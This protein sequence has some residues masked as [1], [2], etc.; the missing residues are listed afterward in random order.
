M[1]LIYAGMSTSKR[2]KTMGNKRKEPERPRRYYSSRFLSKKHEEH[3]ATVQERRLLMERKAMYI[4]DLAPEFGLEIERRG[5]ERLT[6]YPTPTSIE[7]V[8]EFYANTL[9]RG[10][11]SAGRY[12]SYVRG[13]LISYDPD[14]INAFL[15]TEWP[16]E[17]SM[18]VAILGEAGDYEEI[19]RVMCIPGRHFQ[20]NP[21]G[22]PVNILRA[23]LTPLAKYWMAFTHANI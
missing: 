4:R 11:V 21:N 23:D 15:E 16:G 8:K 9:P 2:V 3:Y 17:Q 7:L 18:Y 13:H 10:G 12:M 5:W 19:E 6:T 22:A 20:R 1:N 14:T